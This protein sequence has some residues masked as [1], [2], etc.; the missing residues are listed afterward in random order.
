MSANVIEKLQDALEFLKNKTTIK[1][2]IGI[3]LGSGLGSF[4]KSVEVEKSIPFSEVPHFL[5]PT[6]EGHSGNLIFGKVGAQNVAILQGRNHYYEGHSMESVVFPTRLLALLGCEIIVLTNSAGGFGETMQAGDFMIIEDHI[7]L[8]GTNPLM[9]PNIKELGPRFPDMTEAYDKKLIA[10]MEE[11]FGRKGIRYHKGVYCGVS[12]PTY[13]TPSEVRYLKLIGG[14][15]VGMSTVP[16]AIAANHLGVRVAAVSCITNLA[17]GMSA[18]KLSH[19]EVTETAKKVEQ[20]FTSFL[21]EFVT[22]I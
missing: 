11:I 6:V 8:M 4:V 22:L 7:N 14:K 3:V 13:E 9:G 20:E 15:A 17:A 2:R 18:K 10:T 5:P 16:E 21:S 12:G 19:D 1:P